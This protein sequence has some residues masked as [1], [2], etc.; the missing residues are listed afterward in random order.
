MGD[1]LTGPARG[2][3]SVVFGPDGKT[4]A[5]GSGSG[6]LGSGD[7]WLWDLDL[8]SWK[9]RACRIANRNLTRAEWAQYVNSEPFTYD[10][11]Y[12]KNINCPGSP[13]ELPPH[14]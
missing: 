8:D 12:A 3:T 9:E 14:T 5:S 13:L 7:I 11:V 2:V 10:R 6:S 4:L 1:P